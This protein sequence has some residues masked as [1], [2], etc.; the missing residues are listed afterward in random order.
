[1]APSSTATDADLAFDGSDHALYNPRVILLSLILGPIIVAAVNPAGTRA[2][3][4]TV[5]FF[6]RVPFLLLFGIL[7]L[8]LLPFVNFPAFFIPQFSRWLTGPPPWSPFKPLVQV[9]SS[10]QSSLDCHWERILDMWSSLRLSRAAQEER[11]RLPLPKSATKMESSDAKRIAEEISE[12]W[13]QHV[14]S[15][16]VN[17]VSHTISVFQ[18]EEPSQEFQLPL[19]HKGMPIIPHCLPKLTP[20]P[21]FAWF[22]NLTNESITTHLGQAHLDA[23]FGYFPGLVA[24]DL[25]RDKIVYLYITESQYNKVLDRRMPAESSCF[26]AWGATFVLLQF[27]RRLPLPRQPPA[28]PDDAHLE[29]TPRSK[30]WNVVGDISTVGTC[31]Q[32]E[33]SKAENTTK[34]ITVSGHSFAARRYLRLNGSTMCNIMLSIIV[35]AALSFDHFQPRFWDEGILIHYLMVK[36]VFITFERKQ[37]G[38][39]KTIWHRNTA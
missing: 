17:R 39:F 36:F 38:F 27:I 25:F 21:A 6:I 9:Q 7:R 4:F 34:H 8:I 2:F 37:T 11:P 5:I 24:A 26:T 19:Y 33:R 31:L 28:I 13:G 29:L 23:L 30:V 22:T 12:S 32:D 35:V 3:L 16:V 20:T 1:M 18:S 14:E 15:F 10:L